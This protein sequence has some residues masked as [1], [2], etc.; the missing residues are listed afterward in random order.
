MSK[1]YV[2]SDQRK[3]RRRQHVRVLIAVVV[4]LLTG[5]GVWFTVYTHNKNRPPVSSVQ[6]TASVTTTP[7]ISSVTGRYLFHGTTT[8]ARAV[9]RDSRRADG[10]YDYAHP[11]SQLNTFNRSGYDAWMTSFECP[12]TTNTVPFSVQVSQLTFNC[13]PEF[14]SEA[15]KFFDIYDLANNHTGDQAGAAGLAETRRHLSEAGVQYFGSFD[16]GVTDD[17]CEVITLPV[18]LQKADNSEAKAEIPVAMCGWHYFF[19]TPQ[20]GE[21]EQMKQYAKIMPVFAFVEMGTEYQAKASSIQEDIAHKIADQG[22]EFVIA[23]NPHWV[24]NTEAYNGTLIVYATGNFIF[25]QLEPEEQRS[26]SIDVTISIPYEASVQQW[27]D[28]A[29]ECKTYQDSCL[30]KATSKS[31]RKVGLKLKYA[32]VAGQGGA[33]KLTHRADPATQDAV[34]KRMNWQETLNALQ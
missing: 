12:I 33:G 26:A 21:I 13:R 29:Q 20:P 30:Q 32:V 4:V 31:L 8:W 3:T 34:E 1:H 10:T 22:P 16:P 23:N 9:E 5:S 7:V 27:I 19:R 14:L 18:R 17:I 25:D 28:V 6:K 2:V 11:F 24:Q 15:K